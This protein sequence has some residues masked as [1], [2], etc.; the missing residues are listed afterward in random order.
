MDKYL[1]MTGSFGII[2][3]D[4]PYEE[5]KAVLQMWANVIMSHDEP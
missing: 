5:I 3:S 1:D 4:Y 2:N